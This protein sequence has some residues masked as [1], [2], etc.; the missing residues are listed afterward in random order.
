MSLIANCLDKLVAQNRI[1]RKQADDALALQEGMQGRL[2]PEMGPSAAEAAGALE[3]A[4][5]MA[6]AAQ[7]RKFMAAK[8]A[9]AFVQARERM[10]LHPAGKTAGL[11]SI[12]VRDNLEGGASMRN[13]I[14]IDGHGE[15]VT[16]RLLGMM[17]GAME[18][19]ASRLVGLRQ[20]TVSIWNVVHELF[21]EGTGDPAA[22]AAAKG[23]KDT[24]EYAVDRVKKAGKPLSVLEDW[25]LPQFWDTARVRKFKQSEFVNDLMAEYESGNMRVLDSKGQGEAPRAAVSGIIAN[26]YDEISLGKG[27]S[28]A[29]GG[30]NP[31]MRVFR[32][33]DPEA[34]IRMMKKYGIGSGGLFNTMM[35]HLGKMGQEI[36]TIEI[37][38]PNYESN[39]KNLLEIAQKD[40][41]LRSPTIGRKIKRSITLNS[42]AAVQRT[43]DALTGKLGIAQ[44]EL[45]AGIFGGARNIQTAAKLGSAT[46]SA[47]PGDSITAT[48]AAN[49]NGIPAVAVIERLVKDLTVNRAEA[50]LIARQVN[51]TASAI[52]D[53]ALATRRFEDEIV[54]K[55]MPGK[56]ADTVMRITG[57]N[58]WTEGLKRA[59][60]MEFNG[61]IARETVKSF[62]QLGAEFRGFLARYGFDAADWETLRTTP[63]FDVHGA[64]FFDVNGVSDARLGDRLM[65]AILDERRFAVLEPDARIRGAMT[66]GLQRG[67]WTGEAVRMGT[68][69]KSFPMTFMM[70]H[71][72][73]WAL[74]DGLWNKAGMVT[75][76]FA[77]LTL[78]GAAASQ[79]QNL[80]AGRYPQDMKTPEFWGQA[81][82]RGGGLGM[83]G[84]LVYSTTT[85]GGDGIKD[86]TLGP[87][88]GAAISATGDIIMALAGNKK[89]TGKMLAQ[90]IKDWTPGSSIW[91]AKVA[92]DRLI[93][94]NIQKMVDPNYHETFRRYERR[95]KSEFGQN[96]WWSPGKIAPNSQ[97]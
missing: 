68:Q 30:F 11:H 77:L 83:Y 7:E 23:W 65:S 43:W 50:D 12:L 51:L 33:D 64:K 16:K 52:I 74:Q 24:V 13:A 34:Y 17:N 31:Q 20:D 78:A 61:L 40:D 9:I 29:S 3:A 38:G 75:K 21:G 54:G 93:F 84:D 47:I 67:T 18:P 72:L 46:I 81:M 88:P 86:Y 10:E 82:I 37:L 79:M 80:L 60:G 91:Y 89:F 62:D 1:T 26:A 27:S 73:R 6:K 58:V 69:F 59:W 22:Q 44:S 76:T 15:S 2:Y 66:G 87:A 55:G 97:R 57:I 45:L 4:R 71:G 36:A 92:I 70:T 53:H 41:A 25:R 95:M 85:K 5:V 8:Q 48:L 32:F 14:H 35:Q 42:P 94:D 39:F 49:H 19:Y 96:F 63:L 56:V 28:G 90:H